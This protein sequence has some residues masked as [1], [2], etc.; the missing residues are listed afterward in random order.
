MKD[1]K[2]QVTVKEHKPEETESTGGVG[3]KTHEKGQDQKSGKRSM[4]LRH[5]NE[6]DI[7]SLSQTQK[8][9][10]TLSV[11]REDR[12][13]SCKTLLTFART[14]RRALWAALGL[15]PKHRHGR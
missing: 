11:R 2:N 12:Q 7:S 5:S 15:R 10:G 14:W 8:K 13:V 9:W 4:I 3:G 1:K 6:T